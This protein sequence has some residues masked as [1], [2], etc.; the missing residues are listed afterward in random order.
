MIEIVSMKALPI[1]K[2]KIEQ[3]SVQGDV[4]LTSPQ[5]RGLKPTVA[6]RPKMRSISL[7]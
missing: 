5:S 6:T 1:H 2:A 7:G 4:G 3:D